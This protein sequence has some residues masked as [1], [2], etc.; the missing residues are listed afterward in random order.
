MRII[1]CEI[2]TCQYSWAK[3]SSRVH[4]SGT[5]Q[6]T[7]HDTGEDAHADHQGGD[8][9]VPLL[10]ADDHICRQAQNEGNLHFGN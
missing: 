6:V 5:G 7:G 3:N 2:L 4:G 9:D 8:G 1:Q 10:V